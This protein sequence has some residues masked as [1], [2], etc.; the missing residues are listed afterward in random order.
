MNCTVRLGGNV[1]AEVQ[2]FNI[3]VAEAVV[4]RS[5]HGSDAVV[6]IERVV[7]EKRDNTPHRSEYEHLRTT[8]GPSKEKLLQTLFPGSLTGNPK[9][10]VTFEEGGFQ[11]EDEAAPEPDAKS[12]SPDLQPAM[13]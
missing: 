8:F 9:L 3:T 12:R 1:D 10:P 13:A 7:P 2:K 6:K 5:I 4:L 11:D